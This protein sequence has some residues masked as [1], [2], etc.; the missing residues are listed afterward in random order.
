MQ[1]S[2]AA[3]AT[4]PKEARPPL[5][6]APLVEHIELETGLAGATSPA[7]GSGGTGTGG[8]SATG[9]T[10]TTGATPAGLA[11]PLRSG[12]R[13]CGFAVEAPPLPLPLSPAGLDGFIPG[14]RPHVLEVPW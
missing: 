10:V 1:A 5:V 11:E 6:P 9:G 4:N 13:A 3:T 2:A 12:A 8:V 7:A 14:A